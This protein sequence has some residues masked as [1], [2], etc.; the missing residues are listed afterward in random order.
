MIYVRSLIQKFMI[1]MQG[2]YGTDTLNNFILIVALIIWFVN[3]FVFNFYASLILSLIELSLF[4]LVI[5]RSLSTNITKRSAENRKFLPLYNS[6]KNWFKL[7]H[8]KFKERK[9]FKYLKCPACKAQ[10]RVKNKKGVHT[11]CCPK[12]KNE[13][14][15]KI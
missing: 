11:V 2:R 4:G 5:F 9:D 13:F 8:R 7:T 6:V 1:F 3:I 10:L 15:K 14:K 12:C